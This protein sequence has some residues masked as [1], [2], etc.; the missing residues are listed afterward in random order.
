M[1]G[2]S[3]YS[4]TTEAVGIFHTAEDLQAAVDDLLSQGFNRMDLS[5]LASERA[6]ED[7]LHQ[8]YVPA[9]ELED[10]VEVPTTAFVSTES[11][12]DA[13]GA[14]AG[15]TLPQLLATTVEADP[16]APALSSAGEETTYL[17]LDRRSSRLA[18]ELI[19]RNVGPDV[20]VAVIVDGAVAGALGKFGTAARVSFQ[21]GLDRLLRFIPADDW[22]SGAKPRACH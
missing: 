4:N 15:R 11:V 10:R 19:D 20:T 12:G 22:Q 13:M 9:R 21:P 1:T 16:E 3:A 14:V 7:K 2:Q 6:I 18:R 8:A 5:I 17:E